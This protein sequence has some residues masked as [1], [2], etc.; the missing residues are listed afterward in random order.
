MNLKNELL[1]SKLNYVLKDNRIRITELNK[2]DVPE[3]IVQTNSHIELING[4]MVVDG[5]RFNPNF[6]SA[7]MC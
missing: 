2:K 6:I 5:R 7:H 3:Y 1:V 4:W